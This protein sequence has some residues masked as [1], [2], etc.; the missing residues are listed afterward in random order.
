MNYSDPL[1]ISIILILPAIF[2]LT[3][4]GEGLHRVMKSRQGWFSL[5]VGAMVVVMVSIAYLYL[6]IY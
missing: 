6:R 1:I 4:F 3:L 5:I 2:G